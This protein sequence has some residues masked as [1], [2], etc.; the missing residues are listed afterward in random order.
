MKQ[1]KSVIILGSTGS[2]GRQALDIAEA[3]GLRVVA[4]AAGSD[5]VTIEKQARRFRPLFCVLDDI[6]AARQLKT[7]LLD[8]DIKVLSGRE[9]IGQIINQVPCDVVINAITGAAGLFPTLEAVRYGKRLA[10]ANKESLV[11]AGGFIMAEARACGAEII[12]LDSEHS[13]IF[14][15][16]AGRA[17]HE[18][19]KIILT[20]SGG[21]F[22]GYTREMLKNV[23]LE[24]ALAHP[25][26][27]MGKRITIDS[28]TLMN[29]GFEVIEASHLFGVGPDGI[30]VLI[31]RESI[32]HS[33]VEYFDNS[34]TAGL[35]VPDMRLCIQYAVNYPEIKPA[36]IEPLDLAAIGRLTFGRPDTEAF[37]LLRAAFDCLFEGGAMPAVLNAADEVAVSAFLEGTIGFLDIPA[38]VLQTLEHFSGRAASD[39]IEEI[40]EFDRL[41]REYAGRILDRSKGG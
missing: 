13:T 2:I 18:I 35:S 6:N 19:K 21:P 28:A 4:L 8:T 14:R 37:P 7:A 20:A 16:L 11:M 33:L 32:I 36:V 25:T 38:T 1:S 17:P 40:L 26:W 9:G 15:C 34:I 5:Y 22:Y 10:L 24:Q 12:P 29:K 23:T 27:E 3:E 30:E 31:Q 41:A 39:S